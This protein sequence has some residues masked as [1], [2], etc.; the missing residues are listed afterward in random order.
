MTVGIAL[1][2]FIAV[3]YPINYSQAMMEANALHKRVFKYVFSVTVLSVL[4]NVTKF[5]EAT[6][7]YQDVL[8]GADNKT[9]VDTVAELHVSIL[10]VTTLIDFTGILLWAPCFCLKRYF[11]L[12]CN[13]Y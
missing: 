10:R 5:F 1:E 2:R 7:A 4:F 8:G 12:M 11:I 9:V 13:G 6:V 3:H